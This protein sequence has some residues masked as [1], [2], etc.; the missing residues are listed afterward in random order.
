MNYKIY[1]PGFTYKSKGP[2]HIDKIQLISRYKKTQLATIPEDG[3]IERTDS[4]SQNNGFVDVCKK[5]TEDDTYIHRI[6][7]LDQ[8]NT[9]KNQ[10][11]P[12]YTN[13]DR[14]GIYT[15]S[16]DSNFKFGDYIDLEFT[17]FSN[18]NNSTIE[19]GK[20]HTV[21]DPWGFMKVGNTHFSEGEACQMYFNLKDW[22]TDTRD[23]Q[24]P[25]NADVII[26]KKEAGD[27][28]Q[29]IYDLGQL[30]HV[31]DDAQNPRL[32][33]NKL[34]GD[35]FFMGMH[36]NN[37]TP[38]SMQDVVISSDR[39]QLIGGAKGNAASDVHNTIESEL[40]QKFYLT[41]N[42]AIVKI[43][44]LDLP[45]MSRLTLD[46]VSYLYNR[47]PNYKIQSVDPS[48]LGQIII[49]QISPTQLTTH[50]FHQL[51]IPLPT[52]DLELFTTSTLITECGLDP[53]YHIR[54]INH[55]KDL[56]EMSTM[57]GQG[58]NNDYWNIQYT[59]EVPIY[60][61]EN[62]K[63]NLFDVSE[64]TFLDQYGKNIFG[65]GGIIKSKYKYN[66]WNIKNNEY[67]VL[68]EQA[69]CLK[70]PLIEVGYFQGNEGKRRKDITSWYSDEQ[71]CIDSIKKCVNMGIIWNPSYYIDLETSQITYNNC[72]SYKI[73]PIY[74]S[75]EEGLIGESYTAINIYNNNRVATGEG[76]FE[77]QRCV[78][79]ENVQFLK[80][81]DFNQESSFCN[82]Q[83]FL[84][85]PT[86]SK[87]ELTPFT[88][89]KETT[90][91]LKV[92]GWDI[93]TGLKATV[94]QG[95]G[96]S[97][98]LPLTDGKLIIRTPNSEEDIY[99]TIEENVVK[100]DTSFQINTGDFN[101]SY[102]VQKSIISNSRVGYI[103]SI[104]VFEVNTKSLGWV[105]NDINQ[106]QLDNSL[107][108]LSQI[109]FPSAICIKEDKRITETIIKENT[110]YRLD[111]DLS[112]FKH[113][114]NF[115]YFP[116]Q[117]CYDIIGWY[118][119]DNEGLIKTVKNSNGKQI[120]FLSDQM[121]DTK[122]KKMS[123]YEKY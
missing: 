18:Y 39:K 4:L 100:L 120:T 19:T 118:E 50:A 9:I 54:T 114:Y 28:K 12:E 87:F 102:N 99:I 31:S 47:L 83:R 61:T 17:F 108:N 25:S 94:R 41:D 38:I 72:C 43:P 26:S 42:T 121:R 66:R 101:P 49:Q 122:T 27:I 23:F 93:P 21:Y 24:W 45:E 8:L 7:P 46:S 65:T 115:R 35:V 109:I 112:V 52:K 104:G 16:L 55:K 34:A 90:Y 106:I 14:V 37:Y 20:W 85:V 117:A 6:G 32:A 110:D 116:D 92:T 56:A 81:T 86:G 97:F 59:D 84:A 76:Q 77:I 89:K 29:Y 69:A 5:N 57:W 79:T 96:G 40:R 71:T 107:I 80:P 44:K 10:Q 105:Q 22:D 2:L 98:S 74:K 15:I 51:R 78:R 11:E 53:E 63:A 123:D 113:Y 88:P 13:G 119:V 73:V 68:Q 64:N 30:K 3:I 103:S 111:D 91:C 58:M 67:N 70:F 48:N 33:G 62:I 82:D 75:D 95:N 60:A 36:S 1:I